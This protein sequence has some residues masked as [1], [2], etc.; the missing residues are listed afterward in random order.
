MHILYYSTSYHAKHGGS[1]QSIEFFKE[2]DNIDLVTKKTL[3]PNITKYPNYRYAN[4]FSF[5]SI[6]KKIPLLQLLFFYRRNKFYIKELLAILK[7]NTPDVLIFQ[8]DSNFL[9][10]KKIKQLY[11]DITICT[12]INGSPFDEPFKNI[13]FK[14]YFYKLQREAYTNC[15]LNIFISEFS[16]NR[17]MGSLL[18][19]DRDIVIYNGTDTD[20]FYPILE[21]KKLRLKWEY[22]NDA[23]ILGYLG[24]LDFHKQLELLIEVYSDLQLQFPKLILIIIGDGPALDKIISKVKKLKLED[25]IILR[26]WVNHDYVNEHINC[27]DVAVHHCA[28]AYMNPLK[29]FEYL[30]AGLPVVAPNIPSVVKS[31][32]DHQDLLITGSSYTELKSTLHEII[33]NDELRTKLSH[34]EDV[35]NDMKDNYTWKKYAATIINNIETKINV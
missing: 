31:F 26:G 17:I 10:I 33:S 16:R 35:I 14:N 1:I 22:P 15:D 5:K 28:N 29:I 19:P 13:A 12:Q 21:K 25:K 9:Q 2:L 23:F 11:P 4:R 8:I 18:N 3:F 7:E 32:K 20:K 6:L 34:N 24:T 27:F 30:S